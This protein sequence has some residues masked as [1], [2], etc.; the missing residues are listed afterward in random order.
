M[1]VWLPN[2]CIVGLGTCLCHHCCLDITHCTN[3]ACMY[4]ALRSDN[5]EKHLRSIRKLHL[6]PVQRLW[7]SSIELLLILDYRV[8]QQCNDLS[9]YCWYSFLVTVILLWLD[10][11]Q[12]FHS[13]TVKL[14]G[15]SQQK[16]SQ[17]K[18]SVSEEHIFGHRTLPIRLYLLFHCESLHEMQEYARLA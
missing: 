15:C 12:F 16:L 8:R 7:Q 10:V 5:V 4:Q 1:L 2:F 13:V 17:E 18:P 3:L 11:V 9:H 6:A 14:V